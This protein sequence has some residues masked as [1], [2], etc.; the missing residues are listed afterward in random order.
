[1]ET[2][3]TVILEF[4][5]KLG[6]LEENRSGLWNRV[7]LLGLRHLVE[8]EE[9]RGKRVYEGGAGRAA[10]GGILRNAGGFCLGSE[11]ES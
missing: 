4:I 10:V 11:I 3:D 8:E 2:A 9:E 1:M 6:F 5:F 7:R